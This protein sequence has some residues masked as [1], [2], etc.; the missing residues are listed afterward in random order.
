MHAKTDIHV[1][2]NGATVVSRQF[3]QPVIRIGRVEETRDARND[4][5]LAGTGVSK[6]HAQLVVGDGEL[7]VVDRSRNGTFV[8]GQLIHEP[9]RLGP[10]DVI[11]IDAYTLRVALAGP[12]SDADDTDLVLDVPAAL[13]ETDLVP[14]DDGLPSFDDV[15]APPAES[16]DPVSRSPEPTP[17]PRPPEISLQ[18]APREHPREFSSPAPPR[19]ATPAAVRAHHDAHHDV[20]LEIPARAA[21]TPLADVYRQ[22]AAQFAAPGWGRATRADDA[23]LPQALDLA[24]RLVAQRGLAIQPGAPWPEWLAREVCGLGP[25]AALLDDPS[26]TAITVRGAEAIEVGRGE[27]RERAAIRFS[28]AEAVHAIVERWL[29]APLAN[30]GLI[31]ATPAAGLG[32]IA[33][34]RARAPGGP[35]IHVTRPHASAPRGL[36]DLI[37]EHLLPRAAG[38]LLAEGLRRGLSFVVHGDA[39]AELTPLA[40]ALTVELPGSRVVVLLRSGTWPSGHAIGLAGDRPDALRCARRLHPDWLVVEEVEAADAPDLC[41]AARRPGGGVL[42]TLRAR[43]AEAALLRLAAMLAA[44]SGWPDVTACRAAVASAF[45]LFIGVRRTATGRPVVHTISE[46]RPG[47]RGELAELFTWKPETSALEPTGVEAQV[48]R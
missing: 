42:C 21:E 44:A 5:V 13:V 40:A 11:E 39:A 2:L 10:S 43:S 31:E 30:D 3:S 34:G 23:A 20:P 29:G 47:P 17:H 36:A 27:A 1:M 16:T 7:T 38:D 28:C 37:S 12:A 8:N 24:R 15:S 32:V 46:L 41:A 6:H 48:L 4:I 35:L 26:V 33:L 45:D 14:L 19:D 18:L 22:L 25:L 9:R